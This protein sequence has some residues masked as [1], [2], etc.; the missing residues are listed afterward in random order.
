MHHRVLGDSLNTC[1]RHE[2]PQKLSFFQEFRNLLY[3]VI[4]STFLFIIYKDCG[5]PK[6][7]KRVT[8]GLR[9]A[10][11]YACSEEI[12]RNLS[13]LTRSRR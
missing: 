7:F 10:S 8:C 6:E 1:D 13:K 3:A 12:K 2:N 4:Q 5:R 11:R 9:A